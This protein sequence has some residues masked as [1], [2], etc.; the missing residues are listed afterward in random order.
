MLAFPLRYG[1]R[2]IRRAGP[3][4]VKPVLREHSR[5]PV[6]EPPHSVITWTPRLQALKVTCHGTRVRRI[7]S[8]LKPS[9]GLHTFRGVVRISGETSR[10][11]RRGTLFLLTVSC[12]E[13]HQSSDHDQEKLK[14]H[15]KLAH[16][17]KQWSGSTFLTHSIWTHHLPGTPQSTNL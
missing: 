15:H 14:T 16:D 2:R 5:A 6:G 4:S 10:W 17:G 8:P 13:L 12:P 3:L 11:R 1:T 7:K 9:T